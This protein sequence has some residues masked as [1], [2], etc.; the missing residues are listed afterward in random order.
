MFNLLDEIVHAHKRGEGRGITSICSAHP[1]VLK[2]AT[3]GNETL[4]IESTCNQVNQFGGYTGMTPAAFA[5]YI[6]RLAAETGFPSGKLILGGDH[7]G[8][9]VW[10]NELA[11]SA[12]QKSEDLVR[13]YVQAGYAKIHLDASM[14]LADDD[15]T[16]PLDVEL[17]A[18]RTARLAKVAENTCSD[19]DPECKLRYVIGSEVPP[20]GGAIAH[21]DAVSVT[22][23]E[24]V[25]QMFEVTQNAFF[26]AGLESAWERVIALVV[27]PGVEFGDDFV[28]DYNPEAA[29][30]LV[31]YSE[32]IPFIYEAHS[33]DYQTSENLRNLVQDHFAILKVGPA[34]TF[35]FREAVFALVM[36]ENEVIQP[37]QQSRLIERLDKAMR[38]EP[39]YWKK[40]Y[41]GTEWEMA[42][43]R[44]FSLSDR[45]R[46]YW[47]QPDVKAAFN[48]LLKNFGERPLPLPLL[49]QYFPRQYTL[50]RESR[51]MNS[52]QAILTE[53]IYTV[54]RDY[55]QACSPTIVD[56]DN[57]CGT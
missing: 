34:L 13:A 15:P 9:S 42:F 5:A 40:H 37:T 29:Q 7:L 56:K 17:V 19:S 53:V 10:Q 28:L 4:L 20:P 3:Q 49:S 52:V 31:R 16:R 55:V 46:Y 43:A 25:R 18:Q 38:S 35:A 41:H 57:Q 1:W 6:H 24:D 50:I 27:Q 23:V 11:I 44:K 47:A 14:K 8:P 2:A 22:K 12:M 26:S 51:L 39:A 21:E 32:T 48:L 54:L 45:V 36:I 33:T 30:D